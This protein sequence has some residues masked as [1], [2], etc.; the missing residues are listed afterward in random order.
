MMKI[1]RIFKWAHGKH[2]TSKQTLNFKTNK[3]CQQYV[4]PYFLYN[5][6]CGFDAKRKAPK[7]GQVFPYTIWNNH[8]FVVLFVDWSIMKLMIQFGKVQL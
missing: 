5:P 3:V 8:S 4:G 1:R 2:W 6:H 7:I